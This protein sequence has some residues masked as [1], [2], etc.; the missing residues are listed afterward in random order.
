[1]NPDIILLTPEYVPQMASIENLAHSHPW[2]EASLAGCFGNLYLVY[3]L[4]QENRLAGFA[5]VQQILD[6]VTLLDICVTPDVQGQGL[7]KRILTHVIAQAKAQSAAVIM[8]E[9]RDSNLA[10]RK[11][12]Q[13]M[14]FVETGRR[15]G[16][17]QQEGG[18]EDALL[19]DLILS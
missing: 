19:M 5:I 7:G 8:L 14:G 13:A 11:L 15:S 4:L 12:Y 3:G 10:A 6:E 18:R 1:M 16:Y 2:S 17:Y 9:V